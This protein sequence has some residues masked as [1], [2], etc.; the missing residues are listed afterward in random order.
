MQLSPPSTLELFGPLDLDSA[1]ETLPNT[2]AVFVVW[3][4]DRSAYLAK[5]SMLRRRLQRVFKAATGEGELPR[6][7]LNL[8]GVVSRVDYWL[9]R[10]RFVPFLVHHALAHP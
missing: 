4:G 3:A 2:D 9:S 6:R 5:T 7:G 10:S 8:R 1:L